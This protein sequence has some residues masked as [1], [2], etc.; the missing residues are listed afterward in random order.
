[1]S[2]IF[3][4]FESSVLLLLLL[5]LLFQ[6]K[7]NSS[8]CV[9]IAIV[10]HCPIIRRHEKFR[11]KFCYKSRIVFAPIKR[12]SPRCHNQFAFEW[13]FC[14][15]MVCSISSAMKI[16]YQPIL[17]SINLSQATFQHRE[18]FIFHA[19]RK[20]G[21]SLSLC[22]CVFF[23]LLRSFCALPIFYFH[24]IGR[25]LH[26]KTLLDDLIL[27]FFFSSSIYLF[28]SFS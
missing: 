1:M 9:A 23:L 4:R 21:L 19:C 17:I 24:P 25:A 2:F 16:I 15:R 5:L 12:R 28:R 22:V 20:D 8:I 14:I 18:V 3:L 27:H 26:S 7:W 13:R 6:F 10:T 11:R